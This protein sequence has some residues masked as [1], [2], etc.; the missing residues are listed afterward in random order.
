M[1]LECKVSRSRER[2]RSN[3]GALQQ[4]IPCISTKEST[5]ESIDGCMRDQIAPALLCLA[6]WKCGT[7]DTLLLTVS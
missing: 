3:S 5:S 2:S 7:G 6:L 1:D 4:V